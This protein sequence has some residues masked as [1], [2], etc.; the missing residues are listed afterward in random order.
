MNR[1]IKQYETHASPLAYGG[2]DAAREVRQRNRRIVVLRTRAK[3]Y[4]I[5]IKTLVKADG[6]CRIMK[7]EFHLTTE[8]LAGIYQAISDMEK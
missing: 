7:T 3:T 1:T 5:R 4:L 6:K 8:A 2:Y